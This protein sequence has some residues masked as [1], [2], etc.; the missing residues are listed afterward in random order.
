MRFAV[1]GLLEEA[2]EDGQTAEWIALL[3]RFDTNDADPI[4]WDGTLARFE[5]RFSTGAGAGYESCG[6]PFPRSS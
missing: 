4:E 6:R 1:R 3:D 5:E 2:K